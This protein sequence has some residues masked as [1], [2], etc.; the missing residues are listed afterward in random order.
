MHQECESRPSEVLVCCDAENLLVWFRISIH[1]RR[2][3]QNTSLTSFLDSLLPAASTSLFARIESTLGSVFSFS[4]PEPSTGVVV[5][6]GL[7]MV[8]AIIARR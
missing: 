3:M 6:S 7:A 4:L 5:L 2:A 8:V 1:N